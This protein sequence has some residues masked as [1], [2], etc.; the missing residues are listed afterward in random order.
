[1]PKIDHREKL[2]R[3]E[4]LTLSLNRN[5]KSMRVVED[6]T[7]GVDKGEI[8]GIVGESG[9]GKSV[10]SLS[11]LRLLPR[12]PWNLDSGRIL[13]EGRNLHSLSNEEMRSVRGKDIAVVLQE[14]MTSLNP[15]YTIGQQVEEVVTTHEKVG[16]REA[17]NRAILALSEVGIPA[18]AERAGQYPHQLSGGLKQRAM[19]AMALALRPSLLLADEPTTALDLT[20]QAQILDLIRLLSEDRGMAVVFI[21]HDLALIR[22]MAERTVVMYAGLLVESCNTDRLFSEPLHPYTRALIKVIPRLGSWQERLGTI[23]GS[24]PKPGK[25]PTGCP[26][27]PR[28]GNVMDKCREVLPAMETIENGRMVRCWLY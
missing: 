23:P 19:I 8:L 13:F 2:L 12:P 9:S 4:N 5:N 14:P 3:V 17:K 11:I 21:T 10:T 25:R 20:I 26:Y 1:M 27:N 6:I 22:G 18:A 7:F 15:F 16:R 28:C 24:V